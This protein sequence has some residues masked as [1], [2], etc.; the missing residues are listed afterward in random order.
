M[1]PASIDL[2]QP[3]STFSLKTT[4][5][6]FP[7]YM[8]CPV[9]RVLYR[10]LAVLL[11]M[12]QSQP[13]VWWCA[14]DSGQATVQS[15]QSYCSGYIGSDQRIWPASRSDIKTPCYRCSSGNS[16]WVPLLSAAHHLAMFAWTHPDGHEACETFSAPSPSPM[17]RMNI[18]NTCLTALATNH[19]EQLQK[20]SHEV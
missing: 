5:L 6:F 17:Q 11:L 16:L 3:H 20:L 2:I 4:R 12:C 8:C 10:M 1:P 9:L 7:K 18:G 13:C 15:S 14:R 19:E